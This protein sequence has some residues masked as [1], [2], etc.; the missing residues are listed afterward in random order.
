MTWQTERPLRPPDGIHLI[1]KICIAADQRERQ[2]AAAPDMM[3]RMMA[4][5]L[6]QSEMH[7]QMLAALAAVVARMEDQKK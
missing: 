6:K 2:Q 7:S 3:Q 5:M 1:D 4:V